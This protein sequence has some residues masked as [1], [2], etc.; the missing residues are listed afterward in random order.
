M[1]FSLPFYGMS[2]RF[3]FC[4]L[5]LM[6]LFCASNTLSFIPKCL[7]AEAL[8]IPE[9][10]HSSP[11]TSLEQE[12]L[13]LINQQRSQQELDPLVIDNDL[14]A[15]AREHSQGMARQGFI[16]HNLPFGDLKA[17]LQRA[18]YLYDVAR[19]NVAS[20]Q[21]IQKAHVALLNSL[22]H[23]AFMLA[24]DVT[25]V[26]IGIVQFSA[27]HNSQLYLT[28]IFTNPRDEYPMPSVQT[29]LGNRIDE[30][31]LKNP[32]SLLPDPILEEI[33]S[34]SIQSIDLPFA[35]NEL[36]N[37]ASVSAGKLL[38][39]GQ[40]QLARLEVEMQMVHNPN[41][42][43]IPSLS[44]DKRARIYGSAVR[45]IIDDKNEPAFLVLALIGIAP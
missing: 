39:N 45:K 8:N 40:S 24:K 21:T 22:P 23:K 9:R 28:E 16:S 31:R 19:E 44:L 27:P 38:E 33:A 29:L 11:Y 32:G 3:P 7:S 6:G 1:G 2:T 35:S 5:L 17:R 14:T 26:G 10:K 4:F 42:L 18:G 25:H 12:L 36:Q 34:R 37:L 43:C 15:I 13:A 20:A 41:N 30:L